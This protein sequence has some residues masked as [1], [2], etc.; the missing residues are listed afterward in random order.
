MTFMTGEGA[1][2]TIIANDTAKGVRYRVL[3]LHRKGD[4]QRVLLRRIDQGFSYINYILVRNAD[5]KTAIGDFF[6]YTVGH[7]ESEG[8]HQR[9]AMRLAPIRVCCNASLRRTAPMEIL[10]ARSARFGGSLP[11]ASIRRRWTAAKGYPK[12]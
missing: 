1:V 10:K 7:L 11:R 5:G 6:D 12:S 9:A 8:L 3:H 4:E 2:G